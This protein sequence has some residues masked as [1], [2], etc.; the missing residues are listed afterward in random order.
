MNFSPEEI[1]EFIIEATELLEDSE[2][3]LLALEQGATLKEEYPRIFR[4]LHSVKG[5][6]GMLEMHSLQNHMHQLENL[7]EKFKDKPN[8]SAAQ[9]NFFL[10]GIDIATRI[11]TSGTSIEFDFTLPEEASLKLKVNKNSPIKSENLP[12]LKNAG[13][14]IYIVDDEPEIVD[15]LEEILQKYGYKTKGFTKAIDALDAI[16]KSQPDAV[17]SDMKM[18]E[19]SGLELLRTLRSIYRTIPVIFI[20]GFLTKEDLLE[21]ISLGLYGALEKPIS[22]IQVTSLIASAIERS[23]LLKLTSKSINTVLFQ[24]SLLET[25]LKEKNLEREAQQMKDEI[26]QLL[27]AKNMLGRLF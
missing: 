3:S 26:L 24:Y 6:S 23:E 11:L 15:I 19:M 5:A 4:A 10:S 21:S 13:P 17:I 22:A 7:F 9:I 12:P 25:L 27:K 18:P 8:I 2:K 20:S 16:K 1:N 14:T